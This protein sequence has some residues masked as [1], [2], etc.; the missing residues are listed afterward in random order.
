MM[1]HLPASDKDVIDVSLGLVDEA[2][3][4]IGLLAHR[5]GFV[6]E[7][8]TRSITHM[9]YERAVERKIPRLLFIMDD[10]HPVLP[11]NVDKGKNAQK[12]AKLKEAISKEQVVN[13]FKQEDELHSMVLHSL[14]AYKEQVAPPDVQKQEKRVPDT[15]S[16]ISLPPLPED[17]ELPPDPYRR[18][19]W[20]QGVHAG[21]FFGR[22][23]EIGDVIEALT[24]PGRPPI[25]LLYGKSGV[26]K[27]S[28]L[29]AGVRPRLEE[30]YDIV[31]DRRDSTRG[32]KATLATALKSP[33]DRIVSAW[34]DR[35]EKAD[36]P[37]IVILDQVE[38]AFTT[39]V[40]GGGE[41]EQFTE[42]LDA[43]FA[44][45]K[46]RPNGRLLLSFRKEWLDDVETALN[47]AHL[48]YTKYSLG[49]L[50]YAGIKEV[51]MGPASSEKHRAHYRLS[52][53]VELDEL[54]ASKLSADQQSP[55]GPTLSV[56]LHS[57][58]K[59]A[60]RSDTLELTKKAYAS[61]ASKVLED[62]IQEQ[63]DQLKAWNKDAFESGLIY[64]VLARFTT[65][66][67]TAAAGSVEDLIQQ[68][69]GH[70]TLV[71]EILQK[72]EAAYLL[73]SEEL[74]NRY[75]L[76]HDAL[77]PFIRQKHLEH[78][79]HHLDAFVTTH[80]ERIQQ[81]S[82][83]LV[84]SGLRVRFF[85]LFCRWKSDC[86]LV[87]GGAEQAVCALYHSARPTY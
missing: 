19:T 66:L 44:I 30:A 57:M 87:N 6:P 13:F 2:D 11:A 7:G 68:F 29:A 61:Y 85:A 50:S 27:S 14:F 51:V 15:A 79:V 28:L 78:A 4:Y 65:E 67:G 86:G 33:P 35:E 74:S 77:A 34:H 55:I 69:P 58:W 3:V 39:P 49:R 45:R 83:D 37:L 10:Q 80:V 25:V 36:K 84:N 46:N 43:L 75:R 17:I 5:Y 42:T 73:I 20:F 72:C 62:Y 63:L 76:A 18:L 53:E 52:I 40:E 64:D 26:G 59:E 81:E 56:L 47:N 38:E 22:D 21:I 70:E 24:K 60:V 16:K 9:E 1:E 23:R 48:V 41:L 71:P 82:P 8:H 31:Y 32:L 54:I 12:L